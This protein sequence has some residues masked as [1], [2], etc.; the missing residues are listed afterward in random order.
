M[1]CD[2]LGKM[3]SRRGCECWS[4]MYKMVQVEMKDIITKVIDPAIL[5]CKRLDVLTAV[6][7]VHDVIVLLLR[8]G[9]C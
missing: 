6:L 2:V 1:V 7:T 3:L 5:Y 9:Q 8:C 4:G